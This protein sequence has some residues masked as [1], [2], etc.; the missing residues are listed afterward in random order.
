MKTEQKIINAALDLV[1]EHGETGITISEICSRAHVSRSSLYRY[2]Q[3]LDDIIERLLG[4]IRHRYEDGLYAAIAAN[5]EKENRLDVIAGFMDN[6]VKNGISKKIAQTAPELMSR[7][8]SSIF[9]SRQGFY[10]EILSPYFDLVEK[11]RGKPINRQF[12][13]HVVNFYYGSLVTQVDQ[14]G[15]VD[16]KTSLINLISSLAFNN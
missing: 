6:H 10:E 7:L 3:N 11:L 13:A 14:T 5:P 12:V 2:F 1:V 16:V 15:E 8:A 9:A 4:E